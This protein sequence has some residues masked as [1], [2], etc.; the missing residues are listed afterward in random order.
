[1]RMYKTGRHWSTKSLVYVYEQMSY[2]D[3]TSIHIFHG[4]T[5]L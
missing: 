1:M 2:L 5:N 4:S 3:V